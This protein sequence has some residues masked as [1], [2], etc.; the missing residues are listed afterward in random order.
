MSIRGEGHRARLRHRFIAAG[1]RAFL[2][3]EILEMLLAQV[4]PRGDTKALAYALI[5]A[6]AAQSGLP[7]KRPPLG[8]E[9]YGCHFRRRRCGCDRRRHYWLVRWSEQTIAPVSQSLSLITV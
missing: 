8:R 1:P 6:T 4:V 7:G 2:D 3:H 9:P 5:E